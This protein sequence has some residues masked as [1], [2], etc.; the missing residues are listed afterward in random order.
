MKARLCG[1]FIYNPEFA[2]VATRLREV[3]DCWHAI[4]A[5]PTTVS[6]E[7]ALKLIEFTQTGLPMCL[8][9]FPPLH[10][11]HPVRSL[12]PPSLVVRLREVHD[13]WH[14]VF[15]LPTTVS[16]ELA[17]KLIEFTQTGL[18]MCLH[19][20]PPL[21]S[22]RPVRSLLSPSLVVR[23]REVHDFWHTVFA[24][25]TTVSGELAL[26]LIEFTQTG[27]PMCLLA[28][29]GA[30]IRLSPARRSLLSSIYPWALGA[31]IRAVP[32]A[33]IYYERRFGE[34]LSDLR[35]EWKIA[36]A[37]PRFFERKGAAAS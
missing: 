13:F 28:S 35:L 19:P 20:F 7:L 31:G 30:P 15:A 24:L 14:T 11:P 2:H 25:P 1:S 10:S 3:H 26:K 21:H 29:L 12:L 27:L 22:P 8:H 5:L 6:G 23:L 36:P 37:P 18:P 17:L 9:P 33:G 32:L 4:F 16:G 34:D